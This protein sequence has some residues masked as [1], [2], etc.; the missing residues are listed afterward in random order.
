MFLDHGIAAFY[1]SC[2]Q[3]AILLFCRFQQLGSTTE[4][5]SSGSSIAP[6]NVPIPYFDSSSCILRN[7]SI[8]I[9]SPLLSVRWFSQALRSTVVHRALL[10][11]A[12]IHRRAA[13][14]LSKRLS[15]SP[16]TITTNMAFPTINS[17]LSPTLQPI[18]GTPTRKPPWERQ[19]IRAPLSTASSPRMSES[20]I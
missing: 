19:H 2:C 9:S 7:N 1:L 18:Q 13:Q 20:G 5:H 17:T 14:M 10:K 16:L 15:S 8:C 12:L 6:D 3:K 4:L 11:G